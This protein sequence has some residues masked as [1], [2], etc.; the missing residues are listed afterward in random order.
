[1]KKYA[2]IPSW[3]LQCIFSLS[4]MRVKVNGLQ[5]FCYL[6]VIKILFSHQ[7]CKGVR[8]LVGDLKVVPT[9]KKTKTH[10][11]SV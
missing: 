3:A 10:L 4:V 8:G 1:M 5:W 7:F 2:S 11:P 6:H 9:G